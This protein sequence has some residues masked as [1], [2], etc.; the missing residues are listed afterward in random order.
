[1]RPT[2]HPHPEAPYKN[3]HPKAQRGT[4]FLP[5]E[6]NAN[7]EENWNEEYLSSGHGFSRAK[8]NAFVPLPLARFLRKPS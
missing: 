4:C 8:N 6:G 5:C 2:K 3:C 7:R 1:M